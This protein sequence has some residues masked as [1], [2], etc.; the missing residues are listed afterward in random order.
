MA[1]VKTGIGK[2]KRE[3]LAKRDRLKKFVDAR[4]AELSEKDRKVFKYALAKMTVAHTALEM[5][6]C[7]QDE[8]SIPFGYYKRAGRRSRKT[9]RAR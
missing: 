7:V 1:I 5:I 2:T 9:R 6:K 8:M 3:L 4:K